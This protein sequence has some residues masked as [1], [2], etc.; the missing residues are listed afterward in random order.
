MLFDGVFC[1]RCD[2][3]FVHPVEKSCTNKG[4]AERGC[5]E[6]TADT[7][8]VL[9]CTFYFAKLRS[10]E[11]PGTTEFLLVG[12]AL[13]S[14]GWEGGWRKALPAVPLLKEKCLNPW[15]ARGVLL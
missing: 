14:E 12:I 2:P 7:S 13:W 11:T 3:I 15:E 9:Q 1:E 4:G 10:S 5:I 8:L 6:H